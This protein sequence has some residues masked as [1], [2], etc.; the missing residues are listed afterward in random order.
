MN[1]NQS[2]LPNYPTNRDRSDDG[3]DRENGDELGSLA[4]GA[5]EQKINSARNLL[6]VVGILTLAINGFMLTNIDNE[7]DGELK[8]L[9]VSR[10]QVPPSKIQEVQN[11]GFMVYGVGVAL[12]VL[13]LIFAALVRSFPVPITISGLV[14]YVVAVLGFAAIDPASLARG[15][16]FKIFIIVGLI[17]SLRAA[18]AY[19]RER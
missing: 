16:I 11:L 14:V 19:E 7:I 8:K 3:T 4:Q 12:G 13:F 15:L 9:N 2:D 10:A 6:L 5:R 1:P 17:S 18:V